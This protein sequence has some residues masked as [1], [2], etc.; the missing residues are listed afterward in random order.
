[1]LTCLLNWIFTKMCKHDQI[2][3]RVGEDNNRHI[4]TYY[5]YLTFCHDLSSQLRDC[6]PYVCAE[7]AEVY[8]TV[9]RQQ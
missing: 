2:S 9:E 3:G 6:S 1:M 8:K 7:R 4:K 5:I